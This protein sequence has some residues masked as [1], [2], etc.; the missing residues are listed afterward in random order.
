[1]VLSLA[2]LAGVAALQLLASV[3]EPAPRT[4]D[5][6]RHFPRFVEQKAALSTVAVVADLAEFEVFGG[7]PVTVYVEDCRALGGRLADSLAAALAAKGYPVRAQSVAGVG[8]GADEAAACRVYQ[9]WDQRHLDAALFPRAA[10]PFYV[11]SSLCG[12]DS[13]RATWAAVVRS[14]STLKLPNPKKGPAPSISGTGAFRGVLGADYL[15][16]AVGRGTRNPK[17]SPPD[18]TAPTWVKPPKWTGASTPPPLFGARPFGAA[19]RSPWPGSEVRIAL[20]D[21]RDGSVLW[22][23]RAYTWQGFSNGRVDGFVRDLAAAMP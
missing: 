17:S 23:D 8:L 22:A 15:L 4:S 21:C 13:L 5:P 18:V 12:T 11:D 19:E 20:I 10:A 16:V 9:R 2:S 6:A 14:V 7:K 1:M 3:T